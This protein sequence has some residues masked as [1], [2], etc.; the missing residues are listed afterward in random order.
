MH[1]DNR[2][3]VR[4][5]ALGRLISI[6]GT[7]ASAIALGWALYEQTGS[8][9]WLSFALV[10]TIGGGAVVAPLG[11][12]VGDRVDRRRLMIAAESVSAL[13]FLV[14]AF[15]HT[16]AA[17]LAVSVLATAAG[18]AFG[19]ASGAAVA[20]LAGERDLPWAM[21]LLSTGGNVGRLAGR[22]AA[23]AVVAAVGA[24][25]VF[26]LDALTFAVSAA[27][28]ASVRLS[29]GGASAAMREAAQGFGFRELAAHPVL[30]LLALSACVST[31]VTSFSMTAEV[32][33]AVELGAG[34]LGLGVLTAGWGAGMVL[35]SWHAARALHEGNE[36]TGVLVGRGLMAAGI[37]LTGLA[38]FLP[39]AALCYVLGGLGGGFMG[40]AAQSLI[41]RRTPEH[42]RARMLAAVDACRNLAFGAGALAAGVVGTFA[43]PR[44]VYGLVGVG[45]LI[46]CVPIAALVRRLGGPR[47]LRG[48]GAGVA[49]A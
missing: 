48:G 13:L 17:L 35:G 41:L 40:V 33:L 26:A 31:L 44:L 46:G 39:V 18:A 27:L 45:V 30:R 49:T 38:P 42:L 7:D 10:L 6:A 9:M 2:S 12:W 19:P 3:A 43:G 37:G 23:G 25:V 34:A 24:E 8:A 4:R 47:S 29:F 11:G 32:P 15:A 28:T 36:A 21:S 22:L 1:P 5:L 20:H 16:P 14:L